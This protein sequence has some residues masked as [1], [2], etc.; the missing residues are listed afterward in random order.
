MF[1]DCM[2]IFSTYTIVAARA[3]AVFHCCEV[4]VSFELLEVWEIYNGS[5]TICVTE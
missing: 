1:T 4:T 5:R 3:N 2:I